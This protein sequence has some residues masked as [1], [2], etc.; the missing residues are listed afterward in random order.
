MTTGIIGCGKMA[1]ALAM[2]AYRSGAFADTQLIL[3][4]PVAKAMETLAQDVAGRTAPDLKSIIAQSDTILLCVKPDTVGE[5]MSAVSESSHTPEDLLIIS[6]AAGVTLTSMKEGAGA[7]AR[8]ARVMPNTP[9]LVGEGAAA[10]S[11]GPK[12]TLADGELVER[13]LGAVGSVVHVKENLMNAVTGLSGSGP[14]YVYTFIEALADGGLLKGLPREQALE[15]ATQTV[16]GAAT[17]VKESGLHPA[18]LRDRVTSPGGTT[19]AGLAALEEGALRSTL[20]KA[21]SQ[22]TDR[23]EELGAS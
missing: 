20:I 9:A 13:L 3:F 16:L 19:I 6:I 10:Y 7:S 11:L 14:A 8:F 15:L 4:D 18:V 21:V 2:G 12:A 23:G 1:Q 5:I 17:M 22:A